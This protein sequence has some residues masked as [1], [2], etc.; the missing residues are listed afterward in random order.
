MA[1]KLEKKSTEIIDIYGKQIE[2]KKPTVKQLA[3]YS[4]KSKE[5]GFDQ[6][7]ESIILLKDL[8]I[9]EDVVEELDAEGYA[10]LIEHVFAVKKK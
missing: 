4:E 7:K 3:Y 1:F 5:T 9:P 10:A 8:G 2:I 6:V